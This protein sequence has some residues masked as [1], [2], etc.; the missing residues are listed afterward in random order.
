MF[1]IYTEKL[2]KIWF[3]NKPDQFLNPE[4]QLRFIR[5]RQTN[6]KQTISFLYS[7][8]LLSPKALSD[9]KDFCTKISIIPFDFDKDLQPL[10]KNIGD[11][12]LYNLVKNE[13]NAWVKN[14]GGD[15]AAASD[16]TRW[17][18]PVIE[19]C[20]IYSDFDVDIN[21]STL[22]KFIDVKFP[23][24]FPLPQTLSGTF[25]FNNEFIAVALNPE[26]LKIDEQAKGKA[27]SMQAE[28]IKRATSVDYAMTN[29]VETFEDKLIIAIYE[30]FKSQ[31]KNPTIH[32]YRNYI[33]NNINQKT[34]VIPIK[35]LVNPPVETITMARVE[36]FMSTIIRQEWEISDP[37]ITNKEICIKY[38]NKLK[39]KSHMRSV[40]A[41]TG[42]D[43]LQVA[44][45]TNEEPFLIQ[46]P[47]LGLTPNGLDKHVLSKMDLKNTKF[48]QKVNHLNPLDN[49]GVIGGDMSW[50]EAGAS[51]AAKRDETVLNAVLTIQRGWRAALQRQREVV[52][53]TAINKIH[54]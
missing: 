50:T 23:I 37:N 3:S 48:Y 47:F 36:I 45:F 26:T 7:S 1:Q 5:L 18:T 44:L 2:Y 20:G 21:F 16:I 42:P 14:E 53:N 35:L 13:L 9:L 30:D 22:P 4:N 32:K 39:H 25:M 49:V 51:K 34:L 46:L 31:E 54:N 17:V 19:K 12:K 52:E 10:V 6:P 11:K 41:L 38:L 27:L 43:L 15:P 24:V 33:K 8:A 29:K 40:I 28:L